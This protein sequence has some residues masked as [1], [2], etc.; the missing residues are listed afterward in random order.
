MSP[1]DLT[2]ASLQS[3][4]TRY[5]KA[6]VCLHFTHGKNS[7]LHAAPVLEVFQEN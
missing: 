6:C 7:F 2:D 4:F 1:N 5:R 3:R